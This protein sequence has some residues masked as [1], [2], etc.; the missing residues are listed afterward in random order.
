MSNKNK[1]NNGIIK[2]I[3]GIIFGILILVGLFYLFLALTR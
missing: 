1:K 2:K 3:I